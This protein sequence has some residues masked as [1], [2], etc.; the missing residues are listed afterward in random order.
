MWFDV[1]R[2]FCSGDAMTAEI[3]HYMR[4]HAGQTPAMLLLVWF[5]VLSSV[6]R[7]M[8]VAMSYTLLLPTVQRHDAP[9]MMSAVGD[10]NAPQ[11]TMMA[12]TASIFPHA[13]MS[14]AEG[15]GCVAQCS[16]AQ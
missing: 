7:Q 14:R 11:A 10:R 8:F 15:P 3:S 16:E 6:V 5:I 2:G 9:D 13:F 12:T 4:L 1:G